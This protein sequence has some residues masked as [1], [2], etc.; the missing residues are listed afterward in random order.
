MIRFSLSPGAGSILEVYA[1][2]QQQTGSH[3]KAGGA[4]KPRFLC[5]FGPAGP[6]S[7]FGLDKKLNK[8]ILMLIR[9]A[10]IAPL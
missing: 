8:Q 3:F 7:A 4:Y 2:P 10:M 1:I 5:I 9:S 6:S